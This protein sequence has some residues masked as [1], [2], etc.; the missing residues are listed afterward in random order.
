MSEKFVVSILTYH[1]LHFQYCSSAKM[2]TPPPFQSGRYVGWPPAVCFCPYLFIIR[3]DVDAG[4]K[5]TRALWLV[6]KLQTWRVKSAAGIEKGSSCSW[7]KACSITRRITTLTTQNCAYYWQCPSE[8]L[9]IHKLK[10]TLYSVEKVLQLIFFPVYYSRTCSL[11]RILAYSWQ[12]VLI[13]TC[14]INRVSNQSWE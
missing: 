8:S 10:V 1:L 13:K 3:V 14:F 5:S 2:S 6:S 12:M 4:T 11:S 7:T 9:L